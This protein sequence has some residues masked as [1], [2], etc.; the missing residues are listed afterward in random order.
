MEILISSNNSRPIY[1]QITSQIKEMIM[2]GE[3]KNGDPLPSVRALARTLHISIITVQRA[4]EDLQNEGYIESVVGKGTFVSV[5]NMDF[6]KE[7]KFKEV[8]EK[9]QEA[10]EMARKNGI[11]LEKLT[12][13]LNIFYLGEE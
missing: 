4:Y 1:E 9:L 7:K 2:N 5:H 12:E 8:E 11:S 10:A 13:L 6:I 3:L